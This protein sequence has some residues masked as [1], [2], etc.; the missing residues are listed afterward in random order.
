MGALLLCA[1]NTSAAVFFE[2]QIRQ[3]WVPD[4]D[5]SFQAESGAPAAIDSMIARQDGWETR[6]RKDFEAGGPATVVW[7]KFDLPD[8]TAP[9]RV[10]VNA[11]PWE[12]VDYY[13][14]SG[15]RVIATGHAGT[16]LPRSARSEPA[17]M[18]SPISQSGFVSIDIPAHARYTV[19]ARLATSARYVTAPGLHFALWG[20]RGS[21]A[22]GAIRP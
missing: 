6:A 2:P 20:P 1:A 5:V 3:H 9:H 7:A 19:F 8:A 18:I 13:F 14:V 22:P 15:G 21:A 10:L 11:S 17:P 4:R 12:R 16:L